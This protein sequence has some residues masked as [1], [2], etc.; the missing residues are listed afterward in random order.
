VRRAR[1]RVQ[2]QK[3]RPCRTIPTRRCI[4]T[5]DQPLDRHPSVAVGVMLPVLTVAAPDD[6]PDAVEVLDSDQDGYVLARGYQSRHGAERA[7]I[8]AQL[9]QDVLIATAEVVG[10]QIAIV[11]QGVIEGIDKQQIP[12]HP[13][14]GDGTCFDIETVELKFGV[15][16][17][18]G[19]GKLIEAFLTASGEATVEVALTLRRG[20]G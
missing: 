11:V 17:T 19:T 5:V 8:V 10:H 12:A 20:R 4:V 6:L 1:D 9:G 2:A 18:L 16:A 14:A 7:K 3:W 13:G 15:T